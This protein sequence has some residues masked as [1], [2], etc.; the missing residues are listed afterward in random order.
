MSIWVVLIILAL[1]AFMIFSFVELLR[2]Y[3]CWL[4]MVVCFFAW[5]RSGRFLRRKFY[6]ALIGTSQHSFGR[7]TRLL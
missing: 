3:P 7:S 5:I 1:L 2:I 4:G 6:D